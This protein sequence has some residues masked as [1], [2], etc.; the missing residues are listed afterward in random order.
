ML[1]FSSADARI[2]HELSMTAHGR[3]ELRAFAR[4][5]L[6]NAAPSNRTGD[7]LIKSHAER[8]AEMLA[9]AN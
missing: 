3:A 8:D 6:V 9:G 5:R 7:P 1:G 2:V 4:C